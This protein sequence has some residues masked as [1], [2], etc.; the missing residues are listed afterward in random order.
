MG[1]LNESGGGPS[2]SV[3]A[4]AQAL[5]KKGAV[6]TL[7]AVEG[8][9]SV[10]VREGNGF[11]ATVHS[12]S[13][14]KVLVAS[15]ALRR[16]LRDGVMADVYHGHGIWE[17]P[18]HYMAKTAR[19][20]SRPYLIAPRGMLE[21]WALRRSRWRKRLI[22]WLY[23]CEDLRRADCL[24]AIT[25]GEVRSFREYGLENPIA[26][27]PNGVDLAEFDGVS[28]YARLFEEQFPL[29]KGRPI[30]LF[31]SRIHPKKGLCH[32][33]K[34]W[35]RVCRGYPDWI[36]VIAGS[37]QLGH[38]SEVEGIASTLDLK[39]TVLF[40]GPLYGQLRLAALAAARIFV[41]PSFSEG[42]S[43]ALLEALAC[44]LPVLTTPGCNFPEVEEK[45]AGIICQPKEDSVADGLECLFRLN[46]KEV[47]RMG[48]RG[49]KLIEDNHTWDRVAKQ[50]IEVYKWLL[51]SRDCPDSVVTE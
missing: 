6:V 34:A 15:P 46:D 19:K 43:M 45:Q 23:Q 29:A 13:F 33:V 3:P 11:K 16:K 44:H 21:A 7:H 17:L 9:D 20:Q 2:R 39:D 22:G 8:R 24:H 36:L 12:G 5:A 25:P 47:E 41:L 50:M 37:D 51:G 4:L 38:R 35:A 30:V 1:F 14:P 26:V 40:T 48:A 31:L 49:R 28:K 10:G 18:V 32:L 42:F 27:V